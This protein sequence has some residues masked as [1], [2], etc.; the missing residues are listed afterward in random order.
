MIIKDVQ[1]VCDHRYEVY[2]ITS[3]GQFSH[4]QERVH[5]RCRRCQKLVV[6]YRYRRS[7]HEDSLKRNDE[8]SSAAP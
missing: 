4:T 8:S 2:A 1:K 3:L 6:Y 7:G 5:K